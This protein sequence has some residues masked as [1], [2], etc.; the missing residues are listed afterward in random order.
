MGN[1]NNVQRRLSEGTAS[2]LL[3][4]FHCQRGDIFSEKYLATPVGQILASRYEGRIKTEENHPVLA[5]VGL[6]GRPPQVDFVV[7]KAD[8]SYAVVVESKWAGRSTISISQLLWDLL[9]LELIAYQSHAECYFVL[10]GFKK[11]VQPLLGQTHF[12][13]HPVNPITKKQKT[14]ISIRIENL[15]DSIRAVLR[16]RMQNYPTVQFPN[17]LSCDFPHYYPTQG[18][19][20]TFQVY[21]WRVR[22]NKRA[23]RSVA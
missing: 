23:R 16:K 18:N 2:W 11:K 19:N 14:N 17:V 15:S 8:G 9:R 22:P 7:T 21:T 4:E 3:F 1:L 20:M 10:G 6:V 12:G 5:G 13:L